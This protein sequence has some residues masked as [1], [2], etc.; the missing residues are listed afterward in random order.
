MVSKKNRRG[1]LRQ[2]AQETPLESKRGAS[3]RVF[4]KPEPK[5]ERKSYTVKEATLTIVA[6]DITIDPAEPGSDR[7]GSMTITGRGIVRHSNPSLVGSRLRDF[8]VNGR[9]ASA[10]LISPSP[11]TGD[12]HLTDL[13][14]AMLEAFRSQEPAS[15]RRD[16]TGAEINEIRT[17]LTNHLRQSEH[18]IDRISISNEVYRTPI[19]EPMQ[20]YSM[21]SSRDPARLVESRVA[22]HAAEVAMTF[23]LRNRP[24]RAI[25]AAAIALPHYM[26]NHRSVDGMVGVLADNGLVAVEFSSICLSSEFYLVCMDRGNPRNIIVVFDASGETVTARNFQD[27]TRGQRWNIETLALQ[28][29]A[30]ILTR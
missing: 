27:I 26:L 14:A 5:P 24:S 30:R 4:D 13:Q 19:R 12:E 15:R 21:D 28:V 22:E 29:I 20:R 18:A 10:A 2:P 9:L 1:K 23:N 25:P 16:P 3:F 6:G 8:L 17:R 11:M 7:T